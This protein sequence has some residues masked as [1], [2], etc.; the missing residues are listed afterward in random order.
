MSTAT[1]NETETEY[2]GNPYKDAFDTIRWRLGTLFIAFVCTVFAQW[3][4]IADGKAI[5]IAI[6]ILMA[7]SAWQ[8]DM[9]ESTED[10]SDSESD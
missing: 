6:G 1:E 10:E 9:K 4:P 7:S 3:L 2:T 8:F 5:G